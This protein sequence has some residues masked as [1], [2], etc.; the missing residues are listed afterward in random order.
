MLGLADIISFD[1]W[2]KNTKSCDSP[3]IYLI[4]KPTDTDPISERLGSTSLRRKEVLERKTMYSIKSG[5]VDLAE[6][7]KMGVCITRKAGR[8]ELNFLRF[9]ICKEFS[10]LIDDI[11]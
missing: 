1:S 6:Y 9:T 5:L 3:D 4:W 2:N 10:E 8:L 7:S 11:L